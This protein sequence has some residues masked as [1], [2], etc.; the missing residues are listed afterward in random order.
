MKPRPLI[1]ELTMVCSTETSNALN[2]SKAYI[3][4]FFLKNS[5]RLTALCSQASARTFRLMACTAKHCAQASGACPELSV[6]GL[7]WPT[8]RTYCEH[9]PPAVYLHTIQFTG[10][11][12]PKKFSGFFLSS[13]P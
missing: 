6:A 3:I 7:H 4:I 5:R 11:L 12:P 13:D 8:A 2:Q 10:N 1:G 9:L